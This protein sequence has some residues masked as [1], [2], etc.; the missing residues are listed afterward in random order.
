MGKLFCCFYCL[1]HKKVWMTW[2]KNKKCWEFSRQIL[3]WT[4]RW[5]WKT[6]G[7]SIYTTLNIKILDVPILYLLHIRNNW[8]KSYP[9]NLEGNYLMQNISFF[10]IFWSLD[11]P[12][13]VIY[14]MIWELDLY[15]LSYLIPFI[16]RIKCIWWKENKV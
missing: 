9:N 2:F 8:K 11:N 1:Q 7:L 13:E 6:F 4:C 16:A 10:S 5:I 14:E 12:L 3:C 15:F